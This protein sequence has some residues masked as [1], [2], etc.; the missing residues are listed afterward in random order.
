MST[1][2]YF[3]SWLFSP[4]MALVLFAS[5]SASSL[6]KGRVRDALTVGLAGAATLG[7]VE[8]MKK[9]FDRARPH[10][11]PSLWAT[12][13]SFPSGHA[14]ASAC[15]AVLVTWFYT[16]PHH[17][18]K[19]GIVMAVFALLVGGSRLYFGVHYMSDVLVGYI[20]G[21]VVALA[22]VH[23]DRRTKMR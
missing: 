20:V 23:V 11:D 7:V 19:V 10:A 22:A 5:L 21:S 16:H 2:M 15:F 9:A 6:V 12:D 1:F 4:A 14:A 18:A 13:Q 8:L 17:R 3:W